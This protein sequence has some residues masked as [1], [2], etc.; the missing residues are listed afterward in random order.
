[1]LIFKLILK[2]LC[3]GLL[4]KFSFRLRYMVGFALF[5]LILWFLKVTILGR[6]DTKYWDNIRSDQFKSF[7]ERNQPNFRMKSNSAK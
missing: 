2:R 3:M 7:E 4:E 6:I 1:M 5:A